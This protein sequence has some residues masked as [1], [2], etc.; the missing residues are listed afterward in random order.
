MTKLYAF[1]RQLAAFLTPEGR[2]AVYV[3]LGLVGALATAFGWLTDTQVSDGIAAIG[4]FLDVLALLLAAAHVT[5]E[6]S[7]GSSPDE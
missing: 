5:P 4:H 1:L 3:V 6:S 2:R 7:A